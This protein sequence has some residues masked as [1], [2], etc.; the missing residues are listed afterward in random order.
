MRT[1]VVAD[2]DEVGEREVGER[3]VQPVEIY[4]DAHGAD[5]SGPSTV[6][7]TRCHFEA[8]DAGP[9]ETAMEAFWATDIGRTVSAVNFA[10]TAPAWVLY[11]TAFYLGYL[12]VNLEGDVRVGASE[13]ERDSRPGEQPGV[14][15]AVA[16]AATVA[17]R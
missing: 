6:G 9:G 13:S 11:S 4:L 7:S 3:V 5:T 10:V 17:G 15:V 8:P 16:S 14:R 1:V 12:P 2:G